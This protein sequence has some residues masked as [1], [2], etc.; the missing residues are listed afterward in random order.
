MTPLRILLTLL[1]LAAQLLAVG[2]MERAP[3]VQIVT[4]TPTTL[5]IPLTDRELAEQTIAD[6]DTQ[7]KKVDDIVRW[8]RG[9]A[10]TKDDSQLP[11]IIAKR[12]IAMSYI[13]TAE[14]EIAKGNFSQARSKATDAY[15]KANESYNDVLRRQQEITGVPGDCGRAQPGSLIITAITVILVSL[16]PALLAAFT[17]S[18]FKTNIMPGVE[19]FRQYGDHISDIHVFS[20]AWIIYAAVLFIAVV[21]KQLFTPLLSLF[22]ATITLSSF[23]SGLVILTMIVSILVLGLVIG[24]LVWLYLIPGKD[25]FG[26]D[27][28]ATVPSRPDIAVLGEILVVIVLLILVF[29]IARIP[30][31][32]RGPFVICM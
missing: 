10:S 32:I 20:G 12:E 30:F 3:D 5:T 23:W 28:E 15:S 29:F 27:R 16:L 22:G 4:I 25:G 19:R 26:L 21:T 6:A 31:V 11:A 1:L 8:F 13:V 17:Y 14:D 7:I 24:N 2:C 18:L 9:N